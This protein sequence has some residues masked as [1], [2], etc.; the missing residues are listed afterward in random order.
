M[1]RIEMTLGGVMT[2]TPPPSVAL[3]DMAAL[4][5]DRMLEAH[6]GCVVVLAEE[7]QRM[8]GI[9]TERDF[10]CRV[11]AEGRDPETTPVGTVMTPNPETL[12]LNDCV[13]YAINKM[14]IGGYRNVPVT[15]DFG[16]VVGL[17]SVREV[18]RHLGH[19]FGALDT[20]ER[21][22]S[23]IPEWTDVGGAG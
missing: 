16:D 20:P 23:D 19:V 14:V 8:V 13:T 6:S 9:F 7:D 12:G 17:V 22:D 3:N 18:I 4:A 11:A 2:P 15:D 1:K 5:V 10:L 21:L